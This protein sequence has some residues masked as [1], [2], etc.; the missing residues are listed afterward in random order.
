MKPS[1]RFKE[2]F[3]IALAMMIT[4]AIALGMGWE[5]PFWAGLSVAFCS[6]ATSGESI[7]RGLHRIVGTFLAGVATVVLVA[8][9]PQDRW[10]FWLSMSAL[11]AFLTYQVSGGSRFQTQP[12]GPHQGACD[13]EANHGA[14][15]E[16][17]KEQYRGDGCC[18]QDENVGDVVGLGHD[19]AKPTQRRSS[20]RHGLCR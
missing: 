5:K 10:L 17:L 20:P 6:L 15:S 2:A 8:L 18:Q 1:T 3:K 16:T 9:F 11:L 12:P 13:Q 14:E 7:N 4:Y 19:S